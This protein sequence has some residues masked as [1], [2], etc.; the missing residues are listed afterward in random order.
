MF[1]FQQTDVVGDGP[2]VVV[3]VEN[4]L[5]DLDVL[6][7]GVLGLE[8][9]VADSNAQQVM[10][11]M[12]TTV[13]GCDDISRSDQGAAAHQTAVNAAPEQ[14]DLVG[15]LAVLGIFAADDAVTALAERRDTRVLRQD[16][17]RPGC[18]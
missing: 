3:L 15:E 5:A 7:V 2:A 16:P 6:L 9:I 12:M 1:Q 11:L 14:G 8:V 18:G 13:A 4:D 17:R 10:N